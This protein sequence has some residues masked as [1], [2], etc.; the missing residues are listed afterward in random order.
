M[1]HRN[2]TVSSVLISHVCKVVIK[3]CGGPSGVWKRERS[4]KETETETDGNVFRRHLDFVRFFVC[5][6]FVVTYFRGI[7]IRNWNLRARRGEAYMLHILAMYIEFIPESD[8]ARVR[9]G[10]WLC[11]AAV[12]IGTVTLALRLELRIRLV[13]PVMALKERKSC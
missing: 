7:W 2:M 11:G 1:S 12:L 9:G 8:Y 13:M 6:A 4:K 5:V 10:V 3:N